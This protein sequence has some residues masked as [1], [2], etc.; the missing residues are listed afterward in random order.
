[1]GNARPSFAGKPIAHSDVTRVTFLASAQAAMLAIMAFNVRFEKTGD[2]KEYANDDVYA[3]LEGGV[4]SI[5]YGDNAKWTEYHPPGTWAQVTA[6]PNHLPGK[7]GAGYNV[8]H[9]ML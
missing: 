8:R 5:T 3:F 7:R 1:M 6:E 4:L 2:P 9:S